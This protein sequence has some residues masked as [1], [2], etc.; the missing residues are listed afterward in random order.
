M[1]KMARPFLVQAGSAQFAFVDPPAA[2]YKF[3]RKEAHA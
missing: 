1:I 3:F 2:L